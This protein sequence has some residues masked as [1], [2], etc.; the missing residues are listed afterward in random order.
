MYMPLRTARRGWRPRFLVRL[1]HL[2]LVSHLRVTLVAAAAAITLILVTVLGLYEAD[3]AELQ[4]IQHSQHVAVLVRK[5]Q[6]QV[7]TE[8][9]NAFVY[10]SS[11]DRHA[12]QRLLTLRKSTATTVDSLADLSRGD[13]AQELRV[14]R[15]RTALDRWHRTPLAL[16]VLPFD[17]PPIVALGRLTAALTTFRRAQDSIFLRHAVQ[18]ERLQRYGT[19]AVAAELLLLFVAVL[20]LRDHAGAQATQL[21]Q[22]TAQLGEQSVELARR[23]AEIE[24]RNAELRQTVSALEEERRK[25]AAA[26]AD[27]SAL[28]AQLRHAQK[29]EAVG[30][31]AG[32]LAH[33][34]NNLLTVIRSCSELLDGD[35]AP[36]DPRRQDVTEIRGAADRAAR[37]TR[38]LLAFGSRQVLVPRVVD[39]NAVLGDM[40]RML[41]RVLASN[42]ELRLDLQPELD[43]VS[44]DPGQLE[45]IVV[46][47]VINAGDAMPAGGTLVIETAG[48]VL[49]GRA[50][51]QPH[52]VEAG[53]YVAIRVSDTGHGMDD[54]TRAKIFEP[55]FTTKPQGVG[56][57]LG[58]ATVYGIVKQSHGHI[59]VWSEPGH[60]TRFTIYLRAAQQSAPP[61]HLTREAEAPAGRGTVLLVEDED[62]VREAVRR[63][64]TRQGY[65][66]LAACD[67]ADALRL[68]AEHRGQIDLV[69]S[70]L[71]MPGLSGR[72]VV[73]R[74]RD[75]HGALPALFISGYTDDEVL[76]RGLLDERSAFLQKPF[77]TPELAR[78]IREM[79][80]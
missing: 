46:N 56:T 42:I 31:L 49:D 57:G 47:L 28:E 79:L 50:A 51:G 65:V 54:A 38:Q 75:S 59:D 77:E 55:F 6:A 23:V 8:R 5:L 19:I 29:M 60:G 39:L 22:Q 48:V 41:R 4:W 73:E 34:F 78:R 36:G 10:A 9:I 63:L 68:A 72:A 52:D 18:A 13:V 61:M 3:R 64:L 33:D 21:E 30:R 40:E 67:G 1:S 43:A 17:S 76:R 71:M 27:R 58:L 15:I 62:A 53:E 32:G 7:P 35:I 26:T 12:L 16:P 74:L 66:V 37:L 70:D 14:T 20:A 69:I 80:D 44:V 24:T 2:P 45:Q 25:T 11:G